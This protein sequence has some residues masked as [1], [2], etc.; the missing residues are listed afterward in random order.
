MIWR[1]SLSVGKM[2]LDFEKHLWKVEGRF[3]E[4]SV[5]V[6]SNFNKILLKQKIT[7]SITTKILADQRRRLCVIQ[8]DSICNAS[9]GLNAV[10]TASGAGQLERSH[11]CHPIQADSH[12]LSSLPSSIFSAMCM[13]KI[14][15]SL[16]EP[17]RYITHTSED[18]L[19]LN[20]FAPTPV[21]FTLIITQNFPPIFT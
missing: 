15:E 12:F 4:K 7:K 16:K 8:R 11:E 6:P 1:T 17:E 14:D 20:I 21:Y 10:W 9:C 2:P 13:Q 5:C 18:C 3:F 19:Y